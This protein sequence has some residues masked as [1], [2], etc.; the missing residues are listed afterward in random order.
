[1]SR[2]VAP[3][4]VLVLL[5][6]VGL[7][8]LVTVVTA[9]QRRFYAEHPER[10]PYGGRLLLRVSP[11]LVLTGATAAYGWVTG[12]PLVAAL[13]VVTLAGFGWEIAQRWAPPDRR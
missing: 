13:G 9:R 7:G 2:G 6:L 4:A 8:V 10:R 11:F 1:L 3:S 5:V 12:E